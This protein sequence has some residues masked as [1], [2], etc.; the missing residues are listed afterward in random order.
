MTGSYLPD[1]KAILN[2]IFA[3]YVTQTFSN[4]FSTTASSLRR[5]NN[6]VQNLVNIL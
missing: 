5:N 2:R 1:N 6:S 4:L 3:I